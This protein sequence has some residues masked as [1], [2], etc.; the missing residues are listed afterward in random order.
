MP[1]LHSAKAILGTAPICR[2][3]TKNS[4]VAKLRKLTAGT[5]KAKT[6]L[7][8]AQSASPCMRV[9]LLL[10]ALLVAG[11]FAQLPTG[12]IRCNAT[13]CGPFPAVQCTLCAD[14]TLGGC[15]QD[16]CIVND[17]RMALVARFPTLIC[18][19]LG[20]WL[21]VVP[22]PPLQLHPR[23][24]QPRHHQ[25]PVLRSRLQQHLPLRPRVDQRLHHLHMRP[26]SPS[27]PHRLHR[28]QLQP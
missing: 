14:G 19:P 8:L 13:L 23:S 4:V 18:D 10:L 7:L 25:A 22:S 26:C 15:Y 17:V 5:L 16:A 24:W 1:A 21:L 12:S 11:A 28:P 27:V 20:W 6:S 3:S 2:A 9:T